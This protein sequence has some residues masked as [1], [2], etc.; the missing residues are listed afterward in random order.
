MWNNF[1]FFLK[2][3]MSFYKRLFGNLY[4][5]IPFVFSCF[6]IIIFFALNLWILRIYLILFSVIIFLLFISL[7]KNLRMGN[8]WKKNNE[9]NSL[10]LLL[11]CFFLFNISLSFLFFLKSLHLLEFLPIG[12]ITFFSNYFIDYPLMMLLILIVIILILSYI[13]YDLFRS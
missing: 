8:L 2:E 12:V 6:Y 1:I 5:V 4:T 9:I 10:Y 11:L 7:L 13:L 3:L